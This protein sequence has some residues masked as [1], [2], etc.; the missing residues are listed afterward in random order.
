MS[1]EDD[2]G[3]ETRAERERGSAEMWG[4]SIPGKQ[5]HEPPRSRKRDRQSPNACVTFSVLTWGVSPRVLRMT[6]DAVSLQCLGRQV[7]Q[8]C[9]VSCFHC[10]LEQN[11]RFISTIV[12][13]GAP[14][15]LSQLSVRLGSGHALPVC[16]FE[17][18]VGLC[19]DSSEP[20]ACFG[21]CDSLINFFEWPWIC[22]YHY[23]IWFIVL[24]IFLNLHKCYI[25]RAM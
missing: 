20:G 9:P 24:W 18:R 16:E 3:A 1:C 15:G 21:F 4:N 6:H 8:L 7:P 2:T 23:K 12:K 11:M 5:K 19:A 14:G 25:W 13:G 10:S 17:P 22:I